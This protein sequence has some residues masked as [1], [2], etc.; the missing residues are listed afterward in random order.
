M[1]LLLFKISE[2]DR[3]QGVDRYLGVEDARLDERGSG[4]RIA[5]SET[6]SS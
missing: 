4:G 6:K 5:G 3:P 1:K 2:Q